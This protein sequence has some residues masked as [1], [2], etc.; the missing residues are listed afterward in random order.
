MSDGLVHNVLFIATEN[1]SLYAFDADTNGGA[2]AKPIWQISLLTAKYG[3][4]TGATAVAWGDTGSPDVAPTI[5]IT[6][7]PAINPATNTLYVVAATKESGV[8]FSRLHAI[9]ILNGAEQPHSP[10]KVSATVNGTGNG[11]SG[12]K[13][14]FSPLWQNQ[15][16]ALNYYN[17]FVY[18]GYG[19]HGDDGP[20]HGWLFAY[21]ATTLAQSAVVCTSPNGTGAGIWSAG[22]GLPIDDDA[23]G[24][25]MFVVTGN[26]HTTVNYPPFTASSDLGESIIDFNLANGGL[27]PVDAFTSFN[28]NTL[29]NGDLDQGSGGIL[30]VP[31]QQGSHPHVLI[32]AGKEGRLLVLN[33]DGLGGYNKGGTSNPKALQD[34]T[35]QIKGLWSTPAYWNGNVYIWASGDVPKLFQMN[36]GVLD[37]EPSSKSTI[38]AAFPNPSFSI[39]SNGTQDGIAWAARTDQFNT[40]G[41]AVLYAWDATDLT[42]TIYESD[43]DPSRDAAGPANKF[44][45]PVVTN[46][47]VYLACQKQVDVYGL[48][49]E[50]PTA[51]APIISPNGGPFALS[52]NVSLSTT[53][54]SASIY[55]TLD[56]SVPTPGSTLYENE[57][58]VVTTDTTIRAIAS[59]PNYLESA[60]SSAT[61]T[62]SNQTPAVTFKPAAGTYTSA[63]AVSLSST[64][65]NAHIYYTIGAS[66]PSASSTPYTGTPIAVSA[67]ETIN[68]IAIDAALTSSPVT[69]AA[70]AIQPAGTSIN[71]GSGFSSTAGLT[72]NGN[73]LATNDTRLQLTNGLLHE[74]SSVFWN[75]PIGVGSFTTDFE[76]QLSLAKADGFTFTIQNIGPKALGGGY[77]GL[78]YAGIKKSVAIKFDLY[79]NAGEGT[80]STGVFTNGAEPTVPA[81]NMT[82]SGVVLRSGD[83]ITAHVTYN[84]TTLTMKLTDLVNNKTFTMSKAISISKVVGTS[85]AYVG[86]TGSSGGL[87]A[88]Q[89]LLTWT[90]TAQ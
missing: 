79:N 31:D 70:Y 30:M 68:A 75:Q 55:Y 21:N 46:G 52:V 17:G 67:S 9:N 78:G 83:P 1:D 29:N 12:G 50:E 57:P 87:S 20:W 54:S 38:T 61:F 33:R 22:A 25:R 49:H 40:K 89:K 10:V 66:T 86:F 69:S 3:A 71:F 18:F 63:Q 39:S 72:L 37:G 32:E 7:T 90:Y 16:G 85:K 76:F 80:D 82:S 28:N 84:G 41:P 53:T 47:K 36:T 23:A 65:A 60:I 81:V 34:I 2:N 5:G 27:T 64:D 8:Y 56:G 13:L 48:F 45:I 6:G 42:H 58:I 19:A 44:A 4:G 14:S 26:S 43:T 73:A 24:G 77:A 11:S 74:A 62:S 15:R 35:G 59:T 88:S 51:A